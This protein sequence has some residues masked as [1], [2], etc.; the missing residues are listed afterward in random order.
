MINEWMRVKQKQANNYQIIHD[1]ERRRKQII[2]MEHFVNTSVLQTVSDDTDGGK[3]FTHLVRHQG[4]Q[5]QDGHYYSMR[6]QGTQLHPT[7]PSLHCC[8][9]KLSAA[10][11][12]FTAWLRAGGER[13]RFGFVMSGDGNEWEAVCMLVWICV[14]GRAI[15]GASVCL[16]HMVPLPLG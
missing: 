4:F 9:V 10:A 3:V 1:R 6:R 16:I 11:I 14:C 8:S 15:V 2:N 5:F 7:P 12:S 13:G